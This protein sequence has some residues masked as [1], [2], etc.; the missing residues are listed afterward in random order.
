MQIEVVFVGNYGDVAPASGGKMSMLGSYE[1]AL[2]EQ[3]AALAILLDVLGERHPK[4]QTSP[5][6]IE[7]TPK[8]LG[9]H[10]DAL[11]EKR[12][13]LPSAKN[14]MSRMRQRS[15]RRCGSCHG[16]TNAL[17]RDAIVRWVD[18][19]RNESRKPVAQL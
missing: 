15:R 8:T 12:A 6:N 11:V 19:G 7:A 18:S 5:N 1:E 9:R 3:R 16:S 13:A 4:V 14:F 10:D 17:R 2:E